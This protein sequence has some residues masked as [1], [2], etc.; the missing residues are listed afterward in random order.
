VWTKNIEEIHA[1]EIPEGSGVFHRFEGGEVSNFLSKK[2]MRELRLSEIWIYPIK[3]LGGIRL[4][5]AKVLEKGLEY[6]RRWMLVDE[7]GVFMTQRDNPT[8]ALF[9]LKIEN[10]ELKI[11]HSQQSTGHSIS[12]H[13]PN[14]ENQERVTIWDDTVTACEVSKES[15][16]WFST[17]L[18]LKCRLVYFPEE[19]SRAVD[20]VYKVNDE[21]VSLA[22]GYPFLI[23]GQ[24]SLNF[25]NSKLS[26]AIPMNR[27]RPNFV[28]TGGK[29]NEED[30]WR[31]FT[32]GGNRFVGVKTCARCA[33]PTINQETSEKGIEPTRTLATYRRNENKILFGQNLLAID[34]QEVKE[35]DLISIQT[36][37]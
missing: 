35:G 13:P 21:H 26:Q 4:A 7:N 22:D 9:K 24:G 2:V 33:I 12:L 17:L 27:F 30:T 3:S 23:I 11:V 25:L 31:N 20:P 15:S 8:M 1:F 10:R 28:F 19:N 36:R 5:Q 18:N 29:P 34:H 6:D 14:F 32:I 37:L 16:A